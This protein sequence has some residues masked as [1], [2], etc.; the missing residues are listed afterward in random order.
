[1]SD[2][3]SV[4]VRVRPLL[5]REKNDTIHW[6]VNEQSIYQCTAT[7]KSSTTYNF[8]KLLLEHFINYKSIL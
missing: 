8:G 7:D 2:N 6:K 1:M 4:V 5:P 3:I